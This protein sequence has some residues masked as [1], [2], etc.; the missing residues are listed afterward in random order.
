MKTF[1]WRKSFSDAFAYV[2]NNRKVT[3]VVNHTALAACVA[4][5]L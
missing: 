5:S 1:E 3:T 2:S 4:G